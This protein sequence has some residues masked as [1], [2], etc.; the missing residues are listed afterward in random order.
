MKAGF[1]GSS[2]NMKLRQQYFKCKK[3]DASARERILFG[4]SGKYYN[5]LHLARSSC[6]SALQSA[7]FS[8]HPPTRHSSD[9]QWPA[10]I[11]SIRKISSAKVSGNVNPVV[12]FHIHQMFVAT[13]T[14]RYLSTQNGHL[15]GSD[16]VSNFKL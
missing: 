9:E 15:E 6:Q 10:T 14:R 1:P 16:N 7:S 13:R 8:S 4:A 5:F 12:T 3:S 11:L 2:G